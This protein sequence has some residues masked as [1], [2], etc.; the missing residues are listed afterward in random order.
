MKKTVTKIKSAAKKVG[1]HKPESERSTTQK[2]IRDVVFFGVVVYAA[3]MTFLVIDAE[4]TEVEVEC[5]SLPHP[6]TSQVALR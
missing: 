1:L 5:A 6:I 3:V 2:I 4:S